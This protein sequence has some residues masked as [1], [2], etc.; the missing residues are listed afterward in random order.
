MKGLH[1][2]VRSLDTELVRDVASF[3]LALLRSFALLFGLCGRRRLRWYVTTA[4]VRREIHWRLKDWGKGTS[5]N[6]FFGP[7][8]KGGNR[9]DV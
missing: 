5:I 1:W 3:S 8:N 7:W 9:P 4:T 2:S 6:K